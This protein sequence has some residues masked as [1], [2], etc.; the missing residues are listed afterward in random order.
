VGRNRIK[1][2][3]RAAFAA[4]APIGLDVVVRARPLAATTNFQELEESLREL[5]V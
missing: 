3:V 4:A 1:R 5:K 2:R